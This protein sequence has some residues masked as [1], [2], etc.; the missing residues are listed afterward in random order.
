[1][2]TQS[3]VV[4]KA[5]P[6]ENPMEP[7]QVG[8]WSGH[9]GCQAPYEFHRAKWGR[10]RTACEVPSS[11]SVFKAMTTL[12]LLAKDNLFSAMAGRVIYRHSGTPPGRSSFLRTDHAD[13]H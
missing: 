4:R 9:Q 8:P 3:T 12:P 13:R 2:F 10:L 5:A 7:G 11:Y 1:M 6:R